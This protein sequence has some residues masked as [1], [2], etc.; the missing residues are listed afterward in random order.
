MAQ[1]TGWRAMAGYEGL[2]TKVENS[3]EIYGYIMVI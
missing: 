3:P 2:G 1:G